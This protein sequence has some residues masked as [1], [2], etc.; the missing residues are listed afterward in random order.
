MGHT[1]PRRARLVGALL[2]APLAVGAAACGRGGGDP[3]A[4]TPYDAGASVAT[5]VAA[6]ARTADPARPLTVTATRGGTR[7]TDVT[8]S[9]AEGRQV[10]GTLSADGRRWR[11]TSPLAAG[12]HYTVRVRTEDRAG[13]PGVKVLGFRTAPAA[14]TLGVTFGPDPGTYGVGQPVTARLSAPVT[15]PA[16][17]AVVESHL[18]VTSVPSAGEG[19]WYW[20]DDRTL[21]Y[22]P[23]V[24]WPAHARITAT[25]TLAGLRVGNGLYG[26]ETAPLTL[27]TGDTVV[28]LT[29]AAT[30]RLVYRRDGVVVR[31][32]PVTLGKPGFDTRNGIKVVLAQQAVVRMDSSTVGI[33]PGSPN[34]YDLIVHWATRLT[35]SGEFVHAA[36]WSQGSQGKA[37]VSHGCTGMSDADAHWFFDHTRRGDV[38]E[39]VNSKGPMMA[40]FGNGFGDWNLS[41]DQ[42]RKGSALA[43][44]RTADA[45]ELPGEAA[46]SAPVNDPANGQLGAAVS[47]SGGSG[48]S[49]GSVGSGGSVNTVP[50]PSP[51]GE[52]GSG[53][54]SGNPGSPADPAARLR[55]GA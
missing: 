24:F 8:A 36:P 45:A 41:W 14:H 39:V 55:P 20:V 23:R 11:S 48:E 19:S 34:A 38:V 2:T 4:A 13:H 54:P 50:T 37:N 21:H 26:G 7:I 51:A 9:D 17:R 43:A 30:H 27:T 5:S 28:A 1:H 29:D 52:S 32:I 10:A 35:W 33:A 3:L 16:A 53:G 42:W 46:Q 49:G 15:D 31:T 18:T 40:P 12:V 44:G 6:G 22:R 25:S 47:G